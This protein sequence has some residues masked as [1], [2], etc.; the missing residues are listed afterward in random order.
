MTA[1]TL[2]TRARGFTLIELLICLI[3]VGILAVVGLPTMVEF[4]AEQRV[5]T[6]ATDVV[7]DIAFARAKAVELSRRVI[8]ERV[9]TG[10]DKGWRIYAD[11]NNNAT[12]EPAVDTE[13]KHFDGYGTGAASP[14]GRMYFCSL[15]ADYATNIIFRPD[16][17]IV[18][19]VAA[20]AATDGIY[21]VDPLG[22]ND[23]CNNKTRAILFDLSG[24]AHS[25]VMTSGNNACKGVAPPC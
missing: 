24:R 1:G 17:R 4:V 7:S 5:R 22:D 15:V 2:R 13:L 18:R 23:V 21:V 10:W 16:G 14:T 12:F 11:V 8:I 3:I 19:T 6:A 9:G 20:T 25:R